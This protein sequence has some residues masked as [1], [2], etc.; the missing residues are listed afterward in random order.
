M[1]TWE[2]LLFFKHNGYFR[3][4]KFLQIEITDFCP[5][6]CPQCYKSDAKFNFIDEKLFDNIIVQAAQLNVDRIY[7]NGGEPLL[8]PSFGKFVKRVH[9]Q[10]IQPAV[11]TSGIGIND[12]FIKIVNNTQLEVFLSLNGSSEKINARS[13]EGYHEAICAANLLR[14]EGIKFNINWVAR[15]DNVRDLPNLIL[16]GKKI[17]A[18][19]INVVCNKI[20]SHKEMISELTQSDYNFLIKTIKLHENY[21][22]VQNCYGLLLSALGSPNNKLYGCQAGIREMAVTCKGLFLPCTHLYYPE[23][24]DNILEYWQKSV[25]LK[26][27]R[28]NEGL[29]QYCSDCGLCR[30][31]HAM[32]QV[33]HDNLGLGFK[34]CPI[35]LNKK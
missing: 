21:I 9:D 12:D 35:K 28:E 19:A 2:D 6:Q 11:I 13:R 8:H 20:T 5:L 23:S 33:T 32:S 15:H 16:L 29:L 14:R 7:F 24:Y 18:K 1:T 22:L 3:F 17:G 10:R 31:C 25:Y 27:I 26:K 30:F 4:P 34:N